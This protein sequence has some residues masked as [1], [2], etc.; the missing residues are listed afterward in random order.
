MEE[1]RVAQG[2][3]SVSFSFPWGIW[4]DWFPVVVMPF[5]LSAFYFSPI[6]HSQ[7]KLPKPLMHKGSTVKL[8]QETSSSLRQMKTVGKKLNTPSVLKCRLAMLRGD[9][10]F[11]WENFS[12]WATLF[13]NFSSIYKRWSIYLF[14]YLSG[15]C[16]LW[17]LAVYIKIPLV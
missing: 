7:E 13:L 1:K 10:A 9:I 11:H 8:S 4:S 12:G 6:L 5:Y 14:T 16:V 15:Y 3:Q 2:M 17:A